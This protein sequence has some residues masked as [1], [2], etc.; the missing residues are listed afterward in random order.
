[1]YWQLVGVRDEYVM[2]GCAS[3]VMGENLKSGSPCEKKEVNK[4]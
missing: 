1:M 2:K 3:S 4:N